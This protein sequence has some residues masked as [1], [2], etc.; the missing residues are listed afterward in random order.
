MEED[1]YKETFGTWDK[2]AEL[3]EQ[4]FMPIQIYNDSYDVF[5]KVL[6]KEDAAIFE[7]GCGPGNIA[8]YV[9]K[10]LPHC[11]FFGT[12][13][14]PSMVELAR[15]NNPTA[16]FEVMD[17][18][19]LHELEQKYDGIIAGFCLPYLSPTDTKK[20]VSDCK[21]L[22]N[23]KGMLYVSFVAGAVIESGYKTNSYGD[24]VYF[25]YHEK[26]TLKNLL[27]Q[28]GFEEPL[29]LNVPYHG[30]EVHTIFITRKQSN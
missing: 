1:I 16:T 2:M 14:A 3:Y 13:V 27:M 20:L 4:K 23:N 8:K 28:N 26:E 25:N 11:N 5:C 24:R 6:N 15:K 12:D 30:D 22:L 21:S 10:Q 7:I 29:E 9:I 17:C 19:L 18:R